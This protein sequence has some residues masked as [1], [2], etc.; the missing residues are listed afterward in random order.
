MP[1]QRHVKDE[2]GQGRDHDA[3]IQDPPVDAAERTGQQGRE[4]HR[5]RVLGLLDSRIS[6]MKNSFQ[7]AKKANEGGGYEPG[8]DQ[9]QGDP[10]AAPVTGAV[11]GYGFPEVLGIDENEFWIT[12][13]A[14]V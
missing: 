5:E 13:M 6:T 1:L 4:H 7:A 14:T 3:G 12:K 9:G 2:A 11:D 8:E 10:E